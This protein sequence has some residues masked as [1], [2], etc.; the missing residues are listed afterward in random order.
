MIDYRDDSPAVNVKDRRLWARDPRCAPA[1]AE[2]SEREI[3]VIYRGVQEDFWQD[4][5]PDIARE[6]NYQSDRNGHVIYAAGRSGG[7]LILACPTDLTACDPCYGEAGKCNDLLCWEVFSTEINAAV[8]AAGEMFI[9][10]LADA[11]T[12]LE[13]ARESVLIRGE[14]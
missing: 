11:V 7:W 5:A 3:D 2:L 9:Q 4:I 12:E 13:H 1:Y 6:H 10:R 8:K 14:N